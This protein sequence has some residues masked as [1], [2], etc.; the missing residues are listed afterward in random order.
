MINITCEN[1]NSAG[2]RKPLPSIILGRGQRPPPFD[3]VVWALGIQFRGPNNLRNIG[4]T[5]MSQ[6]SAAFKG[7]GTEFRG[8]SG[9]LKVSRLR[10]CH[11]SDA[12]IRGWQYRS[13]FLT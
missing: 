10:C 3:D 9:H 12:A 6:Y 8:P 1:D 11:G 2:V 5:H 7:L 4:S 13:R